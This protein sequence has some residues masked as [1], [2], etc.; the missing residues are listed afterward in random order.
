MYKMHKNDKLRMTAMDVSITETYVGTLKG[1]CSALST[2][3]ILCLSSCS[4]TLNGV[5][6]IMASIASIIVLLLFL[7]S[8]RMYV[9][10]GVPESSIVSIACQK[11]KVGARLCHSSFLKY[12]DLISINHSRKAMCNADA[13]AAFGGMPQC[14]HDALQHCI[15]KCINPIACTSL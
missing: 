15:S 14:S 8:Y 1:L 2:T 4:C 5:P 9:M 6:R 10:L 11:F 7:C 13:S 12:Q 3:S